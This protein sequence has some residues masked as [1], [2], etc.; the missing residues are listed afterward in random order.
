MNVKEL[1]ALNN[2]I[3]DELFKRQLARMSIDDI[4]KMKIDV[5]NKLK[6][7]K[8]LSIF[9]VSESS[10]NFMVQGLD[11]RSHCDIVEQEMKKYGAGGID[12]FEDWEDDCFIFCYYNTISINY[13]NNNLDTIIKRL[14]AKIY[15]K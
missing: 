8:P 7:N 2:L 1:N 3:G 14:T 4:E 15:K 9:M 6:S 5:N 13:C 12:F 11:I 10:G